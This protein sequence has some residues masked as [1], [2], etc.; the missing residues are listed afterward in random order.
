MKF[1]SLLRDQE[2]SAFQNV[3]R[4]NRLSGG[5]RKHKHKS[6]IGDVDSLVRDFWLIQNEMRSWNFSSV[7]LNS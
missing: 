7:V 3:R 2:Q 4:D 5:I 1:R 6:R